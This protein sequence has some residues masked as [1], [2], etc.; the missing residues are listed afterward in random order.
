MQVTR[1]GSQPPV[2]GVGDYLAVTVRDDTP[3][4]GNQSNSNKTLI[5]RSF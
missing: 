3:F 4:Q 1:N 2:K 5:D